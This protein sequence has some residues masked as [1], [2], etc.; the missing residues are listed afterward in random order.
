M[1]AQIFRGAFDWIASRTGELCMREGTRRERMMATKRLAELATLAH[2]VRHADARAERMLA[3]AWDE[4]DRGAAIADLLDTDPAIAIAYLPF[5]WAGLRSSS[6]ES[7]LATRTWEH[8]SWPALRRYA[9]GFLL[10]T[11]AIAPTWSTR[12]ALAATLRDER[13]SHFGLHVAVLAHVV[14]WRTRMGTRPGAMFAIE[15]HALASSAPTYAAHLI[16]CGAFDP[17]CELI[18][19]NACVN[20]PELHYA[21]AA[22]AFAQRDDGSIPPY[23]GAGDSFADLYHSTLVAALATGLATTTKETT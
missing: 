10:E 15:R 8:A 19:A 14:M 13:A 7:E 5:V 22:I 23:R 6:L 11:L 3:F 1:E 17:L 4:L 20:G 2:G 9:V 16:A 21:R 12:D 18:I